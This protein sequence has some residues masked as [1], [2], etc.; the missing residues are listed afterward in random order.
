MLL[1]VVLYSNIWQ[2]LAC[3]DN[4]WSDS[5]LLHD[6]VEEEEEEEDSSDSIS[7]SSTNSV[8]KETRPSRTFAQLRS[9]TTLLKNTPEIK[10]SK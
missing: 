7:S 1:T 8:E 10:T 3:E 5:L 4:E 2:V 9:N 6:N